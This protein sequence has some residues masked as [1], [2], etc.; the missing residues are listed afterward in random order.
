MMMDLEEEKV[1][2]RTREVWP[3]IDDEIGIVKRYGAELRCVLA[4]WRQNRRTPSL[5]LQGA[6]YRAPQ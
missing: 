3:H 6:E 4:F 2:E 5:I 1:D